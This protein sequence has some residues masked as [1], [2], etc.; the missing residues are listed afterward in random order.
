MT[1]Y[2][3]QI[4]TAQTRHQAATLLRA[5]GCYIAAGLPM[6]QAADRLATIDKCELHA[7]TL[8]RDYSHDGDAPVAEI[9]HPWREWLR[10]WGYVTS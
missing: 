9:E 2:L 6:S 10:S 5:W 4:A 3:A 1:D 8:E 7:Q